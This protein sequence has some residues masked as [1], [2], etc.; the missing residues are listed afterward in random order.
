MSEMDR[1]N[2]LLKERLKYS[3]ALAFVD[4]ELATIRAEYLTR[5]EE[6][7]PVS[8]AEWRKPKTCRRCR[9][10]FVPTPGSSGRWCGRDCYAGGI[11]LEARRAT[12]L[13]ALKE[14]PFWPSHLKLIPALSAVSIGTLQ[15]DLYQ[16][17]AQKFI[18]CRP[19]GWMLTSKAVIPR[20][21]VFIQE[22]AAKRAAQQERRSWQEGRETLSRLKRALRNQ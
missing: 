6:I 16:L 13:V 8:G 4:A 22:A 7:P 17:H 12:I 9:K 10:S 14:G 5:G 15:N 2:E 21:N 11:S 3:D 20:F 1:F 18:K 19:E